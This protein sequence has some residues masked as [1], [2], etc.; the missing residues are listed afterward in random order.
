M[1]LFVYVRY[2]LWK[3][4]HFHVISLEDLVKCW[5]EGGGIDNV[6]ADSLI[7]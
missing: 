1:E 7:S 4:F 2:C 3:G 6:L 5:R